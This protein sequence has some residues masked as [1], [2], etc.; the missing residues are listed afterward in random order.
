MKTMIMTVVELCQVLEYS[1]ILI[2]TQKNPVSS[3][4]EYS[5]HIIHNKYPSDVFKDIFK[6]KAKIKVK[7]V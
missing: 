4:L 7:G 2:S 3:L 5:I 6:V 1:S